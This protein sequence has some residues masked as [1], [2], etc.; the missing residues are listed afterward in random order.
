M[1]L[2]STGALLTIAAA[3]LLVVGF[4]F[5]ARRQQE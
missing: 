3:A 2:T 4:L 1:V 5:W